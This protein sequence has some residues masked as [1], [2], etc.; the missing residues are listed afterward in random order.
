MEGRDFELRIRCW[1]TEPEL[2]E[3]RSR[4]DQIA[5]TRHMRCQMTIEVSD[6]LAESESEMPELIGLAND[7]V[8]D[9]PVEY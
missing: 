2:K 9:G 3:L 5:Q 4:V 8:M 6:R 7:E 1:G